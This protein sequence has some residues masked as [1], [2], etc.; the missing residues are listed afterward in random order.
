VWPG[1]VA[2]TS[3]VTRFV[4]REGRVWHLAVGGL[5]SG[6]DVPDKFM[7]ADRLRSLGVLHDG[8]SAIAAPTGNWVV[9]PVAGH[10]G[11]ITADLD[12][13]LLHGERQNFDPAGHYARPDVFDVRVDRRR[14]EAATFLE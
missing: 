4:A 3:D 10:E 1:S 11:L 5:L 2:L 9:E 13:A 7:F 6:G 12:R 14:R 8:G